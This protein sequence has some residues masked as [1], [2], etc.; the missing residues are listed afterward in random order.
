[1]PDRVAERKMTKVDLHLVK[2]LHTVITE[3]SVSR[4]AMKLA[5]TQPAISAQLKRLRTLTGDA[6]LVRA[7]TGLA[8]TATALALVEPAATLLRAADAIFGERRAGRAFDAAHS[9][10]RFTIAASDYLDP[11][12]LPEL[13]ARLQREAPHARIDLHPLSSDYDYRKSL[14]RGE[15]D[16]A[17]GN[18]LEPPG[19][20]HLGRLVSD[21]IVCLV[22][23]DHPAARNPRGWNPARYLDADHVAPT[24][25]APGVRGV[26]DDHLA[27]LGL[28][29]RI[30]VRSPHF[31]LIPL[32]LAQTHL[33]LTTGRL[34]CSRY[35]EALPL[36][37]VRCPI[38][39]PPLTYY[40]LWH[41]VTHAS[42][43]G[44]WLRE[45]VR[46]VAR[47]LASHALPARRKP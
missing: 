5:S 28:E 14:A 22:G 47:A 36:K 17:V 35:V 45:Q 31:G 10:T 29:R 42:P 13:V 11:L 34:F 43:A 6:L 41:D 8:P 16:L 7:G 21:E 20:L 38:E 23:E 19:E 40:Q 15:L 1:M 37:I 9:D 30:V 32:M 3:G 2:V 18:W 44:R 46:K 24:P 12:F 26:I 27:E 25:F 39:F 33:V 4:A